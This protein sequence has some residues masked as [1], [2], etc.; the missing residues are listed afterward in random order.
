MKKVN[1]ATCEMRCHNASTVMTG[2]RRGEDVTFK[3]NLFLVFN[4]KENKT[5]FSIPEIKINDIRVSTLEFSC[6]AIY[7]QL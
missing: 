2:L 3:C 1:P 7:V 6:A 5:F 4:K